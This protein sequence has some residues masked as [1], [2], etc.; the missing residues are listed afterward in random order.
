MALIKCPECD[1]KIS[2]QAEICP[3]CG[4]ERKG[5]ESSSTNKN[6]KNREKNNKYFLLLIVIVVAFILYP[7]QKTKDQTT[8]NP[9]NQQ[10]STP[11][12]Q[13]R[14]ENNQNKTQTG[15]YHYVSKELGISFDYPS[16]Y[17]VAVGNDGFIY[18]AKRIDKDGAIIP[19][20]ILG[21]YQNF[22]NGVQFLNK[23]TDYMR[24]KHNDLQITIDLVSGVIGDKTTYGLAYNYYV[25][26]HLVVDN[27]Y[28]VVINNKVYMIGSKEE[29]INTTEINNVVEQVIRSLAEGSN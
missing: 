3:H 9:N 21:K 24:G 15:D 1:H 18:I 5:K 22:N 17:Q 20:V 26:N 8:E 16:G 2:D 28:A 7:K 10:Q 27:R 6:V 23:F 29:N 4:Y 14:V 25:D 19:Y 12:D 13:N 11:T